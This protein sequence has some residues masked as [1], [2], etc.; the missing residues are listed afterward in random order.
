MFFASRSTPRFLRRALL[1]IALAT[2]VAGISARPAHAQGQVPFGFEDNLV[3][4]GLSYPIAM[5]F[6]PDGRLLVLEWRS[7]NWRLITGAGAS[8]TA[9][10]TI[11][12]I[13]T[14]GFERG[15][16][17]FAVDPQWPARPYVYAYYNALGS[18]IRISRFTATGDLTD[19]AS[20]AISIDGATRRDIVRDIPDTS[21]AHNGGTVRFGQ[22]GMLYAGL[23]D[24]ATFCGSQDTTNLRGA[25]LRLDVHSLPPGPGPVNLT[26]VTPGDNPFVNHPDRRARLVWA[27]GLRNPFRFH[28]DPVTGDIFVGDVGWVTYEEVN[29]VFRAAMNFGWPFF[30]A[31]A[32]RLT[33]QIPMPTELDPPIYFYDRTQFLGTGEAAIMG[34]PVYRHPACGGCGFPSDYEG[35]IFFSDYYEGIMR[36]LKRYG[37]TWRLAPATGGQPSASD[38]GAGFDRVTDH[39]IGPDGALWYCKLTLDYRDNTG[40]IRRIIYTHPPLDATTPA[41]ARA[42]LYP[43]MPQPAR[44]ESRLSFELSARGA[45]SIQVVDVAGRSVRSLVRSEWL[46]PGVHTRV[47]D[48]TDDQGRPVAAGVYLVRFIGGGTAAS[49]RVFLLR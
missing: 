10:G 23:A 19:P 41:G 20:F 40:Q 7:G 44:G 12:S 48:G 32:P 28:I 15:A 30:E 37:N 13:N 2:T 35:D 49:Q 27:L 46:D 24:D 1:F 36:R 5:Q 18:T 14:D 39:T 3:V 16:L 8:P 9:A 17:G 21:Q 38:W 42:R 45:V 43:P 22:D 33:C 25:M 31:D 26:A 11:D 6:L 29:R 34:G 47:W 4:D